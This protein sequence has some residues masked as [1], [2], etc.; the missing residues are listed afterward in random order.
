MIFSPVLCSPQI[1]FCSAGLKAVWLPLGL[2]RGSVV[3]EIDLCCVEESQHVHRWGWALGQ[4]RATRKHLFWISCV[5]PPSRNPTL[6]LLGK[7][8]I[9]RCHF[10]FGNLVLTLPINGKILNQ[11]SSH[12][13]PKSSGYL[14]MSLSLIKPN[15]LLKIAL[16]PYEN[17]QGVMQQ[18]GNEPEIWTSSEIFL[19]LPQG[20]GKIPDL[21]LTRWGS[22]DTALL[23]E[24][25]AGMATL[26]LHRGKKNLQNMCITDS[27]KLQPS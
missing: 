27:W 1:W 19:H 6:W 7:N 10:P 21:C 20:S 16:V 8:N 3:E 4:S 12:R 24:V 17:R 23:P 5:L 2:C 11:T 9:K 26:K 14:F 22:A 25:C 13:E 15:W 18:A